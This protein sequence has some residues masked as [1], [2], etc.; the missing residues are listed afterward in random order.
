MPTAGPLLPALSILKVSKGRA[1]GKRQRV[2]HNPGRN[3]S[4]QRLGVRVASVAPTPLWLPA[5]QPSLIHKMSNLDGAGDCGASALPLPASGTCPPL[6]DPVS[7]I[8]RS[9]SVAPAPLPWPPAAAPGV[10]RRQAPLLSAGEAREGLVAWRVQD[11]LAQGYGGA[12]PEEIAPSSSTPVR[13]VPVVT[14]LLCRPASAGQGGLAG[15]PALQAAQPS[16]A[17]IGTGSA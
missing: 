3:E 15:A 9:V 5:R 8:V 7:G 4:R 17:L 12:P 13:A 1:R 14:A 16:H 11:A 2:S 6:A 10:R